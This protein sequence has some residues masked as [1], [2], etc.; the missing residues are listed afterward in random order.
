MPATAATATT[1][2]ARRRASARTLAAR[3]SLGGP[4]SSIASGSCFSGAFLS[5]RLSMTPMPYFSSL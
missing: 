1:A 5:L 3:A 2:L 4:S